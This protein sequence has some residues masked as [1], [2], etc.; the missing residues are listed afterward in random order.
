[1]A[2][3]DAAAPAYLSRSSSTPKPAWRR[4]LDA[5]MSDPERRSANLG[6]LVGIGVFGAGVAFF[7]MAGG[8]LVPVF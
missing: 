6:M 3:R 5:E 2:R 1:M 4:I 8:M 7:R